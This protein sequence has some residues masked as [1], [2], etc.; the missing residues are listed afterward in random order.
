[1]TDSEG[2][3]L[4]DW[5]L[6]SR[7]LLGQLLDVRDFGSARKSLPAPRRE[8]QTRLKPVVLSD[9]VYGFMFRSTLTLACNTRGGKPCRARLSAG[10]RKGVCI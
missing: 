6:R 4:G 9:D 8:L 5:L 3:R 2:E 10:P 1:M 7:F